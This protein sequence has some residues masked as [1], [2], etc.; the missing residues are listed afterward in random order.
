MANGKHVVTGRQKARI[1]IRDVKPTIAIMSLE[2]AFN[3]GTLSSQVASDVWS[4]VV[5]AF[6]KAAH[7]AGLGFAWTGEVGCRKPEVIAKRIERQ[8]L[9]VEMPQSPAA[10]RGNGAGPAVDVPRAAETLS[11]AFLHSSNDWWHF[12]GGQPA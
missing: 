7:D 11:P 10:G 1:D 9:H 2:M 3:G 4:P 6:E 8:Q 12:P 5:R